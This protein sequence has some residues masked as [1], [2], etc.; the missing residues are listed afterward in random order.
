MTAFVAFGDDSASRFM[1]KH[2]MRIAGQIARHPRPAAI[3][4]STGGIEQ[5]FRREITTR[6]SGRRGVFTNRER[7]TR[8]LYLITLEKSESLV[9]IVKRLRRASSGD[10]LVGNLRHTR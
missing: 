3:P 2:G 9:M 10:A 4:L 1:A 5:T 8:L 6:L 7:M